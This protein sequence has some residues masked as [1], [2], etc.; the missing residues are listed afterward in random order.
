MC[1]L[2]AYLVRLGLTVILAPVSLVRRRMVRDLGHKIQDALGRDR[3][4]PRSAKSKL[5]LN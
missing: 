4:R 1:S 3:F 2:S 5:D